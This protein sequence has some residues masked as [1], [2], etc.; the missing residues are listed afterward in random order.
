MARWP[1]PPEYIEV[2]TSGKETRPG[3]ISKVVWKEQKETPP[4]SK[5]EQH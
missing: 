1:P 5:P 3:K 4:S 2:D